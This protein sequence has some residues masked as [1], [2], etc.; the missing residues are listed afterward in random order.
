MTLVS[1]RLVDGNGVR[2]PLTVAGAVTVSFDG[3]HVWSF[4]PSLD[5]RPQR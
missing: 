2:V 1:E 4:R 3:Q 5:G